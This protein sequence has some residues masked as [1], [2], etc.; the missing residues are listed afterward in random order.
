MIIAYIARTNIPSKS[1][2]SVHIMK[3]CAEISKKADK[4]TLVIPKQEKAEIES[5]AFSFYGVD[6]FD[7]SISDVDISSKRKGWRFAADAIRCADKA[8]GTKA[9]AVI[10]R[11]V[12]VAALAVLQGKE[13]VLDLHGDIKQITGRWY[14]LM[15]FKPFAGSK[16]LH[17]VMITN[18]LKDYYQKEYKVVRTDLTVLPDA[19]DDTA[20]GKVN[21]RPVFDISEKAENTNNPIQIGY[22][23]KMIK[24]K[25][26]GLISELAA[27][28]P[29]HTYH[30]YGGEKAEVEEKTGIKFTE[31]VLFHGFIPSAQVP[32]TL[33]KMDIMLLPNQDTMNVGGE[34]I[35]KVTSPIKMFEYMAAGRCIVASDLPV[36]KE[37]LSEDLCFFADAQNASEWKNKIDYIE[38]HRQEAAKK[39]RDAQVKATQY[40]WRSRAEGMIR[41]LQ[42]S[43][44]R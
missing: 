27:I 17:L 43:K 16:H 34:N 21:Q 22:I 24:G 10:T 42:W 18:S 32:E 9:Y 25:G 29:K 20:F 40:T 15:K 31:N 39:A 3:L 4:F 12:F 28:D 41:L 11:D 35:G 8:L 19:Y 23:G 33:Q 6:K 30:L 7:I 1:A 38:N 2:H 13:T 36:L 37:I 44:I 26:I 5:D 14:R